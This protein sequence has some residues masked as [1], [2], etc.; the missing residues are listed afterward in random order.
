MLYEYNFI[1]IQ[2]NSYECSC[3]IGYTGRLCEIKISLCQ[4]TLFCLEDNS[5]ACID[6]GNNVTC[7]CVSG[8]TGD[9]CG[10]N[11]DDCATMP[12]QHGGTCV[13]K[14]NGFDCVCAGGATGSRCEGKCGFLYWV[15][16][17]NV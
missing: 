16:Q 10:V 17:K 8:F 15:S 14:V 5:L 4:N 2:G 11:I 7:S 1:I 12:C 9:N 6:H 13:D 3:G